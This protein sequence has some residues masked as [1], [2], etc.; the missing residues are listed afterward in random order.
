MPHR[1]LCAEIKSNPSFLNDPCDQRCI[2][3]QIGLDIDTQFFQFSVTIEKIFSIF[4]G[5]SS[6]G[7]ALAV[8]LFSLWQ[9]PNIII[10]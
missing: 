10:I 5:C 8:S 4:R 6:N 9:P 7:R 1:S 2:S 3:T